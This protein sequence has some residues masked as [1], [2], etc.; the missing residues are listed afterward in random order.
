MPDASLLSGELKLAGR[1]DARFF[2]LLEAIEATGSINRAA[3]T[4]GY[5]YRGAW[6]VLDAA[7]S[8]AT[9]P[10]V[11]RSVGGSRGGGSRLTATAHALLAAWR[12][13]QSRHR[14]FLAEQEDWLLRQ[15][16]L[17]GVLRR[18]SL[19]ATARNQFAGTISAV[20]PGAATTQVAV[21]LAGGQEV[22]GTL[23]ASAGRRLQVKPGLDAIALIDA[24][25][26]TL[27]TALDGYRLSARNQLAGTVSRIDR[28]PVSSLVHLTLPGGAVVCSAVSNDEADELDLAVGLKATAAFKAYA[29][30][31][32]VPRS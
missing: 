28:G 24:S 8:L 13:L 1:L 10:L 18:L 27:V 32:A 21:A 7:A 26:V 30:M 15:P 5:S 6:L 22:V 14:G 2:A 19:K 4:A 29:V 3:A 25:S 16:A 11:E 9:Q 23:T 20:E 17:A 31:V 12:Q